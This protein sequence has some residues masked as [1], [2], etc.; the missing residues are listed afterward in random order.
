MEEDQQQRQREA[1]ILA[2]RENI[3]RERGE[4]ERMRVQL[5]Q[6]ERELNR[7]QV[8]AMQAPVNDGNGVNQQRDFAQNLG[9]MLNNLQLGD[10]EIKV[11]KF[12]NELEKNPKEF[13]EDIERYF[14]VK[15]INTEVRKLIA[16]EH[17][18]EGRGAPGSTIKE[19]L[20]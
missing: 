2:E 13:L 3:N 15:N 9:I 19:I 10:R 6:R 4:L 20:W 18:L 11:P 7:G 16:V 1:V 8:H 5:E 17:A 12:E 14:R